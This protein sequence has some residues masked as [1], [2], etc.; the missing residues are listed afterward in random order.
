MADF[1]VERLVTITGHVPQGDIPVTAPLVALKQ[2]VFDKLTLT[3]PLEF[4]VDPNQFPEQDKKFGIG[5]KY[6]VK[7]T[8]TK[9]D[10]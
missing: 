6:R 4:I 2:L 8:F 9:V 5:T 3:E 7:L 10:D 1:E